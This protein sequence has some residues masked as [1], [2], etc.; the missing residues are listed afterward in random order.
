MRIKKPL[1][2]NIFAK[3]VMVLAILS[4]MTACVGSDT[5]TTYYSD[6]ALTGFTLGTVKYT[7]TYHVTTTS[8]EDSTYTITSSYSGSAYPVRIN[9]NTNTVYNSDSLV[10]GSN[11]SR[12]VC[13]LS[14]LNNGLIYFQDLDDPNVYTYYSN[15][16]SLDLSK[17]RTLRVVSSDGTMTRDYKVRISAY[18]VTHGTLMWSSAAIN[19]ADSKAMISSFTAMKGVTTSKAMYILGYDESGT[20]SLITSVNGGKSWEKVTI[21]LPA[22][23]GNVITS[24][25]TV[26]IY[27]RS[28]GVLTKLLPSGEKLFTTVQAGVPANVTLIGGC[29]GRLYALYE[30]ARQMYVSADGGISWSGEET[31]VTEFIN[32]DYRLPTANINSIVTTTKENSLPRITFVG[33]CDEDNSMGNDFYKYATTWSKVID[34]DNVSPAL[35]EKWTCCIQTGIN[36]PVRL[37]K[38]ERLTVTG[39]KDCMVAI[40]GTAYYDSSKTAFGTLYVSYD[41]GTTWSSSE[42]AMPANYV[43]GKAGM[44]MTDNDGNLIVIG[45]GELWRGHK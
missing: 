38:M 41:N 14:T 20:S 29:A 39:L 4:A 45:N 36:Y 32:N 5:E 25:D 22:N 8:G 11:L 40:G 10:Y 33:T 42:L 16:D 43:S 37:P 13:S 9:Q 26:M 12:V 24:G 23:A 30:G 34:L 27:D 3:A 19:D 35:Q 15:T 1:H 44:V 2:I 21:D 18:Q 28:H 7:R 6:T 31:D 17:E